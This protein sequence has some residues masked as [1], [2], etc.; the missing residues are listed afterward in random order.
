MPLRRSKALGCALEAED[1]GG[2]PDHESARLHRRGSRE[3]QRVPRPQDVLQ[4][5]KS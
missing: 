4:P 3:S 1:A 2:D 5:L